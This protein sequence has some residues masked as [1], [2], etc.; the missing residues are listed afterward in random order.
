[1]GFDLLLGNEAL[2]KRLSLSIGAGKPSHCYLICGP[3]GSGKRT[4][5]SLMA[6]A[7]QCEGQNVPCGVCGACRKVHA[8][9]HPDVIVVDDP[10]K[11]SVQVELSRQVQA[12]AYIRPNEGKKK[13][14]LIPRAQLMTNEAQNALLKL[15]EEPPHYAVFLFLT[16]NAD[17]LLPT[18]RSRSVELR[19]EP[20]A[21]QEAAPWLQRQ[22]PQDSVQTLQ[23]AHRRCGGFLGQ[24]LTCLREEAELPQTA[25]FARA[26]GENDRFAMTALLCSMEKLPRDR[27]I[28][29]F[30]QW[31]MLLTAALGVR[32]GISDTPEAEFLGCRRTAR[33]LAAAAELIQTAMEYCSA[34]I[35][36]GHICGYLA[37]S[38]S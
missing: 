9:V 14:Y 33:E 1:M 12:D 25:E 35:G 10:D 8:G 2:K 28:A 20:V 18:V 30:A 38:L 13:I 37:A 26:F 23:A 32:A 31:K 22:R 6:Q 17:K 29:C 16:T 34:N 7:L 19:M 21:W 24:V 15:I 4:L 27:L 3:E 11:K 36:A 5:A